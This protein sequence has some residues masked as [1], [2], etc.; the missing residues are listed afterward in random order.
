M[1][2]FV[3]RLSH[4]DLVEIDPTLLNLTAPSGSNSLLKVPF[5]LS[6]RCSFDS[7]IS[8]GGVHLLPGGKSSI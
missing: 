5:F 6:V 1:W 8:I 4:L 7:N 2:F 3:R